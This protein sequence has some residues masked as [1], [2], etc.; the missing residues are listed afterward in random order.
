MES[1]TTTP[2][3][4]RRWREQRPP[5]Q[6]IHVDTA[7][8][9]RSST[10]VLR[11][12]AAHTEREAA[13]GAYVAE[14]EACPAIDEARSHLADLLGVAGGGVAFVESASAARTALL[15]AWPLRAGDTV[16][17]VPSEWGPNLSGFT[18]RGLTI[19]EIPV[20]GDGTADLDHLERLLADTPPALVHL[21]PVASHRG[22][23][24]PVPDVARLCRAAGVP[25]WL[26]AAQALGHTDLT[27]GADALYATGR[28]WLT[29]PRGVGILAVAERWWDRLAIDV[30]ELTRASV[31]GGSPPIRLLESQD[32]NIAGRVGLS[33]AVRQHLEAGPA[34]VHRRLS[35]VGALTRE[36]MG[37]LPGWTV[38]EPA[39]V[40]S[41]ITSLAP[42][43]GQDV[44]AVRARLL[45]D[46]GIVATAAMPLRA[47]R[48]MTGPLLRISPHVDCT[49]DDLTR[50]RDALLSMEEAGGAR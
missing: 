14:A 30:P 27:C 13:V 3:P 37:D 48:E 5:A 41:A 36:I 43:S 25:L 19:A 12:M 17:I 46:H 16:A 9:G 23:V 29:G 24:Q 15:A 31:P 44:P 18:A 34:A 50:L 45:A 47:P 35:E 20:H 28:K 26:D 2:S 38:P 4:W 39:D 7:A 10:A 49:A 32:A 11:A 21:T 42:A 40:P 8:A 22:L 33:V 6:R 1:V